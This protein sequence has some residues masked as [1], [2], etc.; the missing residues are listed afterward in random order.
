[1]A[2]ILIAEDCHK[3]KQAQCL[4]YSYSRVGLLLQHV[5]TSIRSYISNIYRWIIFLMEIIIV[6]LFSWEKETLV[7]ETQI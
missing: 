1:M 7:N 5:E 6:L 4:Q 2:S 3:L